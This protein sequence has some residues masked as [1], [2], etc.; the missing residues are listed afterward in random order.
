[1]SPYLPAHQ[2]TRQSAG[3]HASA[4]QWPSQRPTL[5]NQP[6]ADGRVHQP[7]HG[8]THQLAASPPANQP[9]APA[10]Q[11]ETITASRR[12]LHHLAA[13]HWPTTQRP[14]SPPGAIANYPVAHATQP[15]SPPVR[16][17]HSPFGR[18]PPSVDGHRPVAG[19][20]HSPGNNRRR[21]KPA[22]HSRSA[23]RQSQL[24]N[25][26]ARTRQSSTNPFI[27]PTRNPLANQPPTRTCQPTTRPCPPAGQRPALVKPGHQPQPSTGHQLHPST[28]RQAHS[29]QPTPASQPSSVQSVCV[30]QP[31][32]A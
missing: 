19:G 8:H 22:L 17:P 32:H 14:H 13:R 12:P 18:Q 15:P 23:S 29:R 1:M 3:G 20:P 4:S 2:P 24:A 28:G 10:R 26:P 31:A 7:A 16:S 27:R 11:P 9:A 30:E 25:W 5:A 6:P 21:H